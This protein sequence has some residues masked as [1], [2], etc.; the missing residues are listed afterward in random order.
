[1]L[2]EGAE[3]GGLS[4]SM[5]LYIEQQDV[6]NSV[7]ELVKHFRVLGSMSQELEHFRVLGFTVFSRVVVF[8]GSFIINL[9]MGLQF[10]SFLLNRYQMHSLRVP[11]PSGD[12]NDLESMKRLRDKRLK[13]HFF[14]K[15]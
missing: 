12:A 13:K 6:G 9:M 3:K 5:S 15:N 1:M 8:R 11:T 7:V 4:A 10:S 14:S 2:G